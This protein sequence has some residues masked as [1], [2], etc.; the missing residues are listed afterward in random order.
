[1]AAGSTYTPIATQT[2]SSAQASITFSSISG[3][4]TD[5]VLITSASSDISADTNDIKC[6]FNSDT[7][8]NYST[9]FI[10]GAGSGG[11][12]GRSVN[13]SGV[14]IAR[15]HATEYAVGITHFQNYSN[16]SIYKTVLSR[17]LAASSIAISYVGN[18]RSTAAITSMVLT[19]TSASNFDSGSTFT[20]YGISAA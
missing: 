12:S 16:A 13:S 11:A 19:P 4:Y 15:H 8:N 6:Q 17:G 18:W 14:L 9:T 7:G 5:L 2:L 10:Y 20:L 3:S 1:M